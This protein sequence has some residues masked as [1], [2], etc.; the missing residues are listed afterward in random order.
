MDSFS[1][2]FTTISVFIA[3]VFLFVIYAGV[4]NWRAMKAKGINPI[5]AQAEITARMAT[6]K[7]FE[8]PSIEDKLREIDDLHSRGLISDDEHR[9]GRK[10]VLGG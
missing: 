1:I 3:L 9:E 7:L 4:K 2:Y 6:G 8:G 10:R 5:T